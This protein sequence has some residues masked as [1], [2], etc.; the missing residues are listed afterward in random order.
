MPISPPNPIASLGSGF[1]R[2]FMA[3][4][5]AQAA[6]AEKLAERQK[7]ILLR[8]L[9]VFPNLPTPAKIAVVN[10]AASLGF[11]LGDPEKVA[12]S[13]IREEVENRRDKTRR[14]LTDILREVNNLPPDH[15]ALAWSR[16]FAELGI[17]IGEDGFKKLADDL[18][19]QG[20]Q[21]TA[22]TILN[23]I[24]NINRLPRTAQVMVLQ[25]LARG[26]G[27]EPNQKLTEIL[28]TEITTQQDRQDLKDWV[29]VLK[30]PRNHPYARVLAQGA[31]NTIIRN[32]PNLGYRT[33]DQVVKEEKLTGEVTPVAEQPGTEGLRQ[34]AAE[35]SQTTYN[36]L[37][38][39]G[40]QPRQAAELTATI[41]RA[42]FGLPLG[43]AFPVDTIAREK[44]M[45]AQAYRQYR[46]GQ[47]AGLQAAG[48]PRLTT[49]AN[50]QGDLVQAVHSSRAYRRRAQEATI[51]SNLWNDVA[52]LSRNPSGQFRQNVTALLE[53]HKKN[54]NLPP[55]V[56]D[57]ISFIENMLRTSPSALREMAT[58]RG[59][60]WMQEA[61]RAK[62]EAENAEAKIQGLATTAR[63][64]GLQVPE[65]IFGEKPKPPEAPKAQ[66]AV[67][68]PPKQPTPKPPAAQAPK[69]PSPPPTTITPE[70]A[71]KVLGVVGARR[72]T[73]Q[74]KPTPL[75]QPSP[76]PLPPLPQ[77]NKR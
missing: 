34:K 77:P 50:L 45:E 10:A 47:A 46:E 2:G 69:A 1:A 71:R 73:P 27:F 70:G 23:Q 4:Q 29:N 68:S 75:P 67:P 60:R 32:N 24:A 11:D 17:D 48:L 38:R 54:P 53:E 41:T 12:E 20:Y 16:V 61:T 52:A 39:A 13:I 43:Q 8:A 56:R 19:L 66:S 74:P 65:D 33:V 3:A 14:F 22:N 9:Q 5:Q 26:L 40:V 64:L 21:K 58:E 18:R 72:R 44:L 55:T 57:E 15:Q 31:V 59:Y 28:F 36:R 63:A 62:S 25:S 49:I 6:A 76:T 42:V 35:I 7:E 30:D 51:V 37:V